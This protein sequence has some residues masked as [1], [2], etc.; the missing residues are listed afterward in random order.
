MEKN[1]MIPE[2]TA[3]QDFF[4]EIYPV[5]AAC[6]RE[7]RTDMLNSVAGLRY[8]M[9]SA[10]AM[11][12]WRSKNGTVGGFAYLTA[13]PTETILYGRV[14]LFVAPPLRITDMAHYML[15]WGQSTLLDEAQQRNLQLI[16]RINICQQ[17]EALATYLAKR[18]FTMAH[19]FAI[20]ARTPLSQQ[21]VPQQP[22]TV[23]LHQAQNHIAQAEKWVDVYNQAFAQRWGFYP[24]RPAWFGNRPKKPGYDYA[25]DIVAL[26]PDAHIAGFGTGGVDAD[27]EAG[28]V[29]M[30]AVSADWR[31]QHIGTSIA[32]ALSRHLSTYGVSLIRAVVDPDDPSGAM[33]FCRSQGFQHETQMLCFEKVFPF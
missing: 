22:Q 32:T 2:E 8:I 21:P 30:I 33:Q 9:Q 3:D 28:W 29:H 5:Y 1:D 14:H 13:V 7:D 16:L 6:I 25:L 31:R 23:S 24:Y 4:T 11:R 18:E 15:A 20:L 26:T 27:Y 12:I 19:M 10:W 17:N